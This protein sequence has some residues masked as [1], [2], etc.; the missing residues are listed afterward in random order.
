MEP[1]TSF[2]G[3]PLPF[4]VWVVTQNKL[5]QDQYNRDFKNEMFDL[6]GLDNYK[7]FFE[8]T[9]CGQAKCA[10]LKP[11]PGAKAWKP[12]Q[13]CSRAC[14]YDEAR[15]ASRLA[16]ILLMNVAKA[17]TML[18]DPTQPP[19]VLMVFD[20]GHGVEA[21]LDN[22]ASIVIDGDMLN[23]ID[24][25]YE[26]YFSELDL[27][28]IDVGMR[29]LIK[30]L[31]TDLSM[32]EALPPEM[33]DSKKFKRLESLTQKIGG[34]LESMEKGIQ[35]VS[36]SQEKVDLRPLKVHELFKDRFKFPTL[37]LSA[38]LL[39]KLGFCAMT[40]VEPKEIDWFNADSPFPLANREIS[41][42]WRMGSRPFN[43]ENM[44]DEM[45]NLFLRIE[46]MMDRHPT[47]RGIIHTHTYKLAT[48]ISEKMQLKYRRRFLFPKNAADQKII[49][50]QHSRSENTVLL[51]PSMTEGVDLKDALCR[52]TGMCKVPYLP[53]ND[54]VVSAR[55]NTDPN[56]YAYRTAMTLV[57][58]PG[59]G[60]RSDTDY[61]KTYFLDPGFQLF[62]NRNKRLFPK[63]FLDSIVK[64]YKGSY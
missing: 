31:G 50:E 58:A 40:G 38:T 43:F 26:R 47:E 25:Q 37:F 3:I 41:Y 12:P 10:R 24:Y 28:A 45:S 61:C 20:E 6:R 18:K 46:E 17:L 42:F 15:A 62:I 29:K 4:Q 11:P 23:K 54:P 39:S 64:G 7:C 14:G 33:R 5:L 35:Y 60:V 44:Q 30:R 9:T 52:F 8:D 48:E 36:C 1:P 56:W 2:K 34:V 51:S 53:T 32:E 63:W 55:M 16:P 27:D 13:Y 19:P 59:R 57:Q 21:A 22:E 49:L